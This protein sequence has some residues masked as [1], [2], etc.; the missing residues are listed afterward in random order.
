AVTG[1][2]LYA[3]APFGVTTD[4]G[5]PS[6]SWWW[7]GAALPVVTGFLAARRSARDSRPASPGPVLQACVAASCA[8]AAAALVLAAL[9]SVTIPL[10][11]HHVPLQSSGYTSHGGCETCDPDRTVI[12]PA[13]RHEYL[14]EISVGQAGQTPLAALAIAPFLGA[15][16][17]VLGA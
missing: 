16:L 17:G 11:P 7:L 1:G 14:A 8:A 5:G 6:L 3:L 13:L 12:P 4:P 9:T 10:L 15:W 2:V